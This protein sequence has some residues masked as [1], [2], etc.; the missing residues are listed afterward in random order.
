MPK[1]GLVALMGRPNV[2]KSTLL[3][4]LVGQ[5][6]AIVSNK[7]QTTRNRILGVQTTEECQIIFLDTPGIHR[8][9]HLLNK[10]MMEE[11]YD[12]LRGVDLLVQMVDVS[13]RYGKG[14]KYVLNLVQ[15]SQKPTILVLNKIDL[16]SKGKILPVLEFYNQQ[17][18]YREMIPISALKGDNFELLQE[19]IVENLPEGGEWLYPSEYITDQPERFLVSEIIREKVLHNTRQ[20]LPYSTA[21][22]VEVF[23]ESRREKGFMS[24]TATIVVDKGSQKKIVIGRAGQMV[25]TIGTEA[26]IDLQGFLDVSKLYLELNVKVIEGWRDRGYLLDELGVRSANYTEE[27]AVDNRP[28][29]TDHRSQTE[30][31]E[32]EALQNENPGSRG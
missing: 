1:S 26:R 6:V 31:E 22:L 20:E 11:V 17:F 10:R 12:S 8:P 27:L 29:P 13:E 30:I 19:K 9:G 25:K 18:E 2:G 24:I 32:S 4:Q 14:E 21:V 28:Q 3:N 23:D 5:K 7:P 16:I 15:K